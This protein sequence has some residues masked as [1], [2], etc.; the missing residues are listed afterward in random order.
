MTNIIIVGAF[1][2]AYT[3][4]GT[5][6]YEILGRRLHTL[7]DS[8]LCMKNQYLY[9]VLT[10]KWTSIVRRE[11]SNKFSESN[12]KGT[13]ANLLTSYEKLSSSYNDGMEM[14]FGRKFDKAVVEFRKSLVIKQR[15]NM[16]LLKQHQTSKSGRKGSVFGASCSDLISLQSEIN[17]SRQE[18]TR[19]F[20]E[21][22]ETQNGELEFSAM[23]HLPPTPSMIDNSGELDEEKVDI[24]EIRLKKLY[25]TSDRPE[26]E[27]APSLILI[28]R[29]EEMMKNPPPEDWD[30]VEILTSKVG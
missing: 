6:V 27:D 17:S 19:L 7:P 25:S 29:C 21:S 26:N 5:A 8:A 23:T 4:L 3:V 22:L 18:N 10:C 11:H 13:R 30:G 1:I 24:D 12:Q 14:Y 16:L 20:H 2:L 9:S 28:A 15:I